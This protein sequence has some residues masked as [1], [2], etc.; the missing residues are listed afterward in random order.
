VQTPKT[1]Y[2]IEVKRKNFIDSGIEEEVRQKMKRLPIRAGMTVRPVLVYAG[3]L[4]KSVEAD[5]YFDAIVPARKL[6]GV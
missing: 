1:A 5:G 6:F 3:E 2:V 4:S